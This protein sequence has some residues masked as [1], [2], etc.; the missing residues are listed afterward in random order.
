[1]KSVNYDD[2]DSQRDCNKL[3]PKRLSVSKKN[4]DINTVIDMRKRFM[5]LN[6]SSWTNDY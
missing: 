2:N 4:T 1:M 6:L 5:S 3:I